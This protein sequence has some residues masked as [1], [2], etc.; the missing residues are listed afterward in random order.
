MREEKEMKDDKLAAEALSF[1]LEKKSLT[2]AALAERTGLAQNYISQIKT[3]VRGAPSIKALQQ[4]AEGLGLS[5]LEFLSCKDS[6][7][8]DIVF[9]ERVK[10]VPRAGG[11]LEVDGE[12]SGLYSFHSSFIAR[13]RGTRE[14]MKIFQIAG[15][16]MEPTLSDSDLIMVNL[17]E[18]AVR[19]G[20]IYLV[21]M[22]EELMVKRLENRPGGILLLRSD[23]RNYADIA[24]PKGDES[25]DFRIFG[26][27]VW[28][29]REY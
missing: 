17:V 22:E 15:D 11:G 29:C 20:Y 21:R 27:M 1:W 23:N 18:T 6:S 24:V 5:L 10:A 3:G 14:S 25:I 16:S 7:A 9:V 28:S 4:I 8:P 13:K 2:Q 19:S 26:R 12:H